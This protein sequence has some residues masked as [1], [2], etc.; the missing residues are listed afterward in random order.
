MEL[1]NLPELQKDV[2][3]T[4]A[5]QIP[6][7]EAIGQGELLG[8]QILPDSPPVFSM[9]INMVKGAHNQTVMSYAT[10][11]EGEPPPSQRESLTKS[12]VDLPPI[13]IMRM[14]DAQTQA[15]YLMNERNPTDVNTLELVRE[16]YN[17]I[18]FVVRGY[19][20]RVEWMRMQALAL[21]TLTFSDSDNPIKLSFDYGRPTAHKAT[22][23]GDNRWN[24]DTDGDGIYDVNYLSQ[25]ET[26]MRAFEDSGESDGV[27]LVRALTSKARIRDLL[28]NKHSRQLVLGLSWDEFT[29]PITLGAL[30][31]QLASRGL[32]VFASYDKRAYAESITDGTKTSTRFF[33]EDYVVLLPDA[34]VPI[35]TTEHG[36]ALEA[37]SDPSIEKV[38]DAPGLWVTVKKVG[39]GDV[40]T[41]VTKSAG[42]VLPSI[43]GIHNTFSAKV[44]S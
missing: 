29:R 38:E 14:L 16:I 25:L 33:P 34:G 24:V 36:T 37:L 42:L 1:L 40:K 28:N 12:E 18:D 32:P 8:N 31:Q 6:P 39:D 2:V 10:S 20:S 41:L 30:N 44:T 23:A 15:R 21:G 7:D 22:L 17:D 26:W 27:E 5:R 9:T 19:W 3:R 13:K 43:P 35:G 11:Y 4:Y